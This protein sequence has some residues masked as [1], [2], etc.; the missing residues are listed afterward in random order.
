M[1]SG[2]TIK[3]MSAGED[4]ALD[5]PI[6]GSLGYQEGVKSEQ[7]TTGAPL[8]TLFNFNSSMDK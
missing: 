4:M 8:L 7:Q 6:T 3:V 1:T 5:L 2:M